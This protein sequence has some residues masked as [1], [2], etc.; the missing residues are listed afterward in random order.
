LRSL[1]LQHR[2]ILAWA[3]WC[4]VLLFCTT[5]RAALIGLDLPG[6]G[7]T[8][9]E[10]SYH[11]VTW[12]AEPA[13]RDQSLL[14]QYSLDGVNWID[15][16]TAAPAAGKLRWRV[17][18]TSS[19]QGRLRVI[20]QRT[21]STHASSGAFAIV[22][23]Q[24]TGYVW[25]N[26]TT[27]AAWAAR[28]GAGSLTY[29]GK[30][31]LL[32]GWHPGD[33]VNFPR[34]TNNEVWNSTDGA[35]WTLV[36]PNTF[37]SGYNP[38]TDWEGRHTGGYVVHQKKMWLVGGD[39]N[40]GH[41]QIDVWNSSDGVTWT[42]A[43]AGQ[44]VPW[45]PRALHHTVA[46]QDKIWV[47]GGQTMPGFAPAPEAFY[48]DVW[49][50]PDGVNWQQVTPQ[51]ETWSPR[52]AIMGS[53]VFNDRLWVLGGGT[54]DTPTTPNREY[55]NDVWST[56]DGVNWE[57]HDA[58][59]G[60]PWSAREYHYVTVFDDRMWVI[61]GWKN[62]DRN[63]VWYSSDGENWY[64][65][66]GTPW[67]GRH[68]ASVYVHDD[69][70]WIAAG[71]AMN[72]DV[73]KMEATGQ[74]PPVINEELAEVALRMRGLD[75][76]TFLYDVNS[77]DGPWISMFL[78]GG[79]AVEQTVFTSNFTLNFYGLQQEN[80]IANFTIDAGG[81]IHFN[82]FGEG[83]AGLEVIVDNNTSP[84]GI[85]IDSLTEPTSIA[86]T[87][88]G[89]SSKR[90]FLYD[91]S[92][93]GG[94]WT[95]HN[96]DEGGEIETLLYSNDTFGLNYLDSLGRNVFAQML[97]D[98]EGNILFD[99]WIE[100][101]QGFQIL[102]DNSVEPPLIIISA[103]LL[104]DFDQNGQ[105][106]NTDIQAM[107]DALTNVEG[108]KAQHGLTDAQLLRIADLDGNGAFTNADIQAM[109]DRLTGGGSQTV[110]DIS[111]ELFGDAHY[112]DGVVAQ[113]PEPASL[114]LLLAGSAVVR[115][116]RR[117]RSPAAAAQR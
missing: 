41:Y 25:Q 56:A 104:G 81:M 113:V 12:E 58:S 99:R 33:P 21:N 111:L 90:V 1:L 51:G 7:D 95:S 85:T 96:L 71:S 59:G 79:E 55:Y 114:G 67:Q 5:G 19:T 11:Y 44:P 8:W 52:G 108:Y 54:Y 6:S 50:S 10:D 47:M 60:A 112:L 35:N 22:P 107:L 73:W 83:G 23:T 115:A 4:A 105:V 40:Q 94:P 77:P 91:E 9:A 101:G 49:N 57:R 37:N 64:K 89:L 61:G 43:N 30:M 65:A 82:G 93:P 98:A 87:L 38:N 27:Q 20:D 102:V 66:Y 36:K 14:A 106:S 72:R 116:R 3:A 86:L 84:L 70:L 78:G 39:A 34:I 45:G 46:F 100:N 63:D 75:R 97:I 48:N 24:A 42:Q 2:R 92:R 69:A 62:G 16:A 53:V 31:W 109:L 103:L 117:G 32:G 29:D 110:A 80:T 18:D 88:E 15:I 26:V 68:A 13:A 17:P 76:T 28:D 74:P